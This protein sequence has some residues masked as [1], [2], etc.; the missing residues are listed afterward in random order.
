MRR[1]G[2][3]EFACRPIVTSEGTA[4]GDSQAFGIGLMVGSLRA[5][6]RQEM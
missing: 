6:W 1:Q 5:W 4:T 3:S 2:G